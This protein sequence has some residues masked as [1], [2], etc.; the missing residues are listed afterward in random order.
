MTCAKYSAWIVAFAAAMGTVHGATAPWHVLNLKPAEWFGQPDGLRAITNVVSWQSTAGL[1]PKNLDTTAQL[2]PEGPTSI[3]GT[4]D[5]GAS[6]GEMRFLGRAG[7]TIAGGPA[8]AA[9]ARGLEAILSAQYPTGGW[10]QNFPPGKQYH[11]HITFN[12][13]AMVGV[14]RFLREVA[15]SPDLNFVS[16]PQRRAA[17][18]AFDRGI[19]CI[20]R[21]QIQVNGRRTVWCAQHD[22]KDLSPRPAR[23]YE[24]ESLSGSESAGV[25]SLLM[26]LEHPEKEICEAITAGAAWFAAAKLSGL[27]VVLRDGNRVVIEDEAAPALWARFYEI[28]GNRPFFCG[29]DGVKRYRLADLEPERRNGY[30]WY[31]NWGETVAREFAAWSARWNVAPRP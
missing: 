26:S 10:P 15:R 11:R 18:A 24:R 2:N 29:R 30:A 14:M 4:F 22:E 5:N 20:L 16:E 27:R 19:Q 6:V 25:L 8:R 21:C 7:Q 31:G 17:Q 9:F 28:D 12:D 23:S 1:W 13:G 3:Q